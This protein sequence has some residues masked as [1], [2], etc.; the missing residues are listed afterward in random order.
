MRCADCK[1]IG[2]ATGR[3]YGNTKLKIQE[4]HFCES[5]KSM[6]KEACGFPLMAIKRI[7][8]MMITIFGEVKEPPFSDEKL[9]L[10]MEVL[11]S[12]FGIHVTEVDLD[13][14]T[15]FSESFNDCG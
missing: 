15:R 10:L 7:L 1:Y 9:A 8:F 5:R 2:P 14:Q 13:K 4:L 3:Y 6:F 12:K 11:D